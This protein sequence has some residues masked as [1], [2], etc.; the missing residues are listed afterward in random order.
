MPIVKKRKDLKSLTYPTT[1]RNIEKQEH[2]YHKA[3]GERK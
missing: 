3:K 2:T 1:L